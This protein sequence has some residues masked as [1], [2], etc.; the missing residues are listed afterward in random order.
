MQFGNFVAQPFDLPTQLVNGTVQLA[1]LWRR[2][3][4]GVMTFVRMMMLWVR[5]VQF[6]FEPLRTLSQGMGQVG[7][8]GCFEVVSGDPEMFHSSRQIM[9][10]LIE[11]V[12]LVVVRMVCEL[13]L[14]AGDLIADAIHRAG[15]RFPILRS[16][17]FGKLIMLMNK[18]FEMFSQFVEFLRGA[19]VAGF[20]LVMSRQLAQLL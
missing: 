9:V 11:V 18:Q 13:M 4:I 12:V 1:D 19:V 3:V 15:D 8:A 10:G 16:I 6:A 2:T 20:G 7:V 17:P 14:P 5:V